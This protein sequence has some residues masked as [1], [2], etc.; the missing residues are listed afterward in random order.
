MSNKTFKNKQNKFLNIIKVP[1]NYIAFKVHERNSNLP[2]TYRNLKKLHPVYKK[3]ASYYCQLSKLAYNQQLWKESL[4]YI[5]NAIKLA[6]KNR[7]IDFY[8]HKAN[9]LIKL[10]K[11]REAITYLEYYLEAKP[12]NPFCNYELGE[13]YIN[14]NLPEQAEHYYNIAIDNLDTESNNPPL[15]QIYYKLGLTQMKNNKYSESDKTFSKTIKHDQKLKSNRFGIG[16]FHEYYKQWEFAV[17]AYKSK[18]KINDNDIELYFKL[19]EL[20]DKI[21]KPEEALI[22]YEDALQLDK[23]QSKWHYRLAHCYEQIEDYPNAAKW[24]KNA[25]IRQQNH[26]PGNYRRL[27]FVLRKMGENKEALEAYSEAEL[28]RRSSIVSKKN[29]G[30]D[31]KKTEVRYAI[32]YEHY[33]VVNNMIFYESLSGG[34]IMGNPYAV[35]EQ[36]YS[37]SNFKNYIHVWVIRSFSVIPDELKNKDNIIFVKK[38]SDAYFRYISSAKYLICNST[39]SEYF[40]RK[41]EQY[42][43]QTSHGIFYKTV[44]RDSKGSPTGVAGSTR[45]LLQAS[46]IIVPNEFMAEKQPKAYSIKDIQTARIAKIRY[47]SI[48]ITINES[49]E[50]KQLLSEKLKLNPEKKTV[51]YAPTWR[52]SSKSSNRFDSN[53]LISDLKMLATLD[54]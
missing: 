53:K 24:Y 47:L 20:L 31:V 32:S 37:D 29:H 21:K 39:F 11:L 45:N 4:K 52:G 40:V 16:V 38:D 34:R 33:P 42:Y 41:T 46:H 23:S 15:A 43:L 5:N 8:R 6:N 48:D 2:G 30:K 7:V 27:A 51:F 3:S 17:T 49:K 13:C 54:A 10:N 12:S 36:V 18:L 9:V 22:Y 28:F 1:R 14:I 35:F 50:F 25:I 44:G 26:S 19:A